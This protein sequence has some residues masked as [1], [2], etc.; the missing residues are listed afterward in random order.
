MKKILFLFLLLQQTGICFS[1]H[2]QPTE[3]HFNRLSVKNGLPEDVITATLQ[4]RE[5]YMWIGTQAG[6]VRYDG[7][8][9][10]VY[11][12]DQYDANR[13]SVGYIYEDRSGVLWIATWLSGMYRYSRE[14]DSFL[15]CGQNSKNAN[16]IG[17][18]SYTHLT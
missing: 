6:L 4:D 14:T 1:Q 10:R 17:P 7:Y 2:V 9:A 12:F 15:H 5:G 18:V 13:S 11:Q 8:A 3:Y 16:S